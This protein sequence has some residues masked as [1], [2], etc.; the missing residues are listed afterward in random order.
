M[1]EISSQDLNKKERQLFKLQITQ[2]LHTRGVVNVIIPK[3]NTPRIY[4]EYSNVF[5]LNMSF[6]SRVKWTIFIF[7]EWRSHE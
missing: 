2:C 5:V 7:H 6:I 3:F 4:R 1:S